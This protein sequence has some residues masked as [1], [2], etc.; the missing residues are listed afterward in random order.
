MRRRYG[1]F[2]RVVSLSLSMGLAAAGFCAA[3]QS[4]QAQSGQRPAAGETRSCTYFVTPRG[5]DSNDGRSLAKPFGSLQ[6]AMAALRGSRSKVVCIR[7][8]TYHLKETITLTSADNGETWQYYAPDGVGSAVLDGGGTVAFG[9]NME[10]V[11]NVT[12]D[13]LTV[14]HFV[15]G[16]IRAEG[17]S[18]GVVIENNDVGHVTDTSYTPSFAI[19]LS[20]APNSTVSHNS[21][22][23]TTGPGIAVYAY[24]A[25]Q[26]ANGDLVTGN[27]LLRNS[28][29]NPDTGALYVNMN[30]AGDSGGHVT[31]TNNYVADWGGPTGNQ[32][33]VYLDDNASNVT[34]TGNVLGPPRGVTGSN[35]TGTSMIFVHNGRNN[36]ISNNIIDLGNSGHVV[37]VNWSQD[38]SLGMHGN[39]FTGNIVISSYAGT[40]QIRQG[41]TAGS[42][43]FVQNGGQ[44][45]S[46]FTIEGNLYYNHAGG[47]VE[48]SGNIAGDA[49]PLVS[50]P[51]IGHGSSYQLAR[52]S[53]AYRVLHF[54][55][56]VGGWGPRGRTSPR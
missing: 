37:T 42:Y 46:A 20:N 29:T 23:D 8:G 18:T 55:P 10:G 36:T 24:Y 9:I 16:G 47:R 54:T 5:D 12:I 14:H 35:Y 52:N 49:R 39:R 19:N 34:V 32:H 38:N 30:K 11:S 17:G 27:L 31:L 43:S 40:Q 6:R 41:S 33:A 51:L 26:S 50:D 53:P 21:V 44:P 13:G 2:A 45:A 1:F 22:H 28:T 56:I 4:G 48:S 15:T 7:A 3:A 25:G